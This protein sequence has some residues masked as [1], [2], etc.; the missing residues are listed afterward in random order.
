MPSTRSS[1][2]LPGKADGH[3]TGCQ[4]REGSDSD[5]ISYTSGFVG[6]G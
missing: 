1:M 2:Q 6:E 3:F 4:R 5:A